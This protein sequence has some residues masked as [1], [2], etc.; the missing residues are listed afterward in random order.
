[1]VSFPRNVSI[2]ILSNC[3]RHNVTL[4]SAYHVLSQVALSRVLIRRY[5]RG[6]ISEEEWEYRK[7]QPMLF[8]GLVNL[9]PYWN[10]DWFQNGGSGEVGPNFSFYKHVPPFM[11]LGAIASKNRYDRELVGGAPHFQDLMSFGLFLLRC[12]WL[13]SKI[14][15]LFQHPLFL[16]IC[17]ATHSSALEGNVMRAKNWGREQ[18]APS[19]GDQQ[20]TP[21]Q[22]PGPI[23]THHGSSL[24][25][26]SVRMMT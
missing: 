8:L 24:G 12:A 26:V 16:E 20:P 11:P 1:M 3:R 5:L 13:E 2:I 15:K 22:A 25:N 23:V 19:I 10:W 18:A 6:E 9:R 4:N 21:L 14:E 17:I 7:R